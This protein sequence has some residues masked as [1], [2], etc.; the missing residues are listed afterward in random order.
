MKFDLIRALSA[1]EGKAIPYNPAFAGDKPVEIYS[2]GGANPR[3]NAKLSQ[4]N[5][6]RHLDAMGGSQAVDWLADCIR[7]YGDTVATAKWHL[8]KDD[9]TRLVRK[10]HKNTPKDYEEGPKDLYNLLR[11]PN[12]FMDYAELFDLMVADLLLVGNAYWYKWQTT[13]DGKPLALYR[14]APGYVKIVPGPFG[15]KRYEYS[16][17][18]SRNKLDI[19]PDDIVHMRLPNPNN[20]YYG[21][22]IVQGGG[23]AFDLELALTDTQASYMENHADPSVV[24]QSERRVPRDVFK[25]LHLQLRRRASGP[26]NAGELLVLEAG[27]KADTLSHS[28]R[29]NLFD[30]LTKLSRDRVYAKFRASPKLFGITDEAGGADKTS[31]ARREFDTKTM[32]PFLDK[33]QARVTAGLVA[34]WGLEYKID[35]SYVLPPEELVQFAGNISAVPGIKVREVRR[36]LAPLGLDESTGDETIDE[37][38]LNL[39]G[40]NLDANGN[41]I[42]PGG[43]PAA[44]GF[45]DKNL[46]GEPGRP[47]KGASTRA[48]P[49]KGQPT[50]AGATVVRPKASGK[51]LMA[52]LD[53]RLAAVEQKALLNRPSGAA[54]SRLPSEKRPDDTLHDQRQAEVDAAASYIEGELA[55]AARMLERDLMDRADGKAFKANDVVARIRRSPAWRAFS[56][57]VNRV[58]EDGAKRAISAAVVQHSEQGLT[59]DQEL[60]YDAL[61]KDSLYRKGGIQKVMATLRDRMSKAVKPVRDAGGSREQINKIVQD[62]ITEWRSG[63]AAKIAAT[64]AVAA[65]NEGTLAVAEA[66]GVKEVFV[67]DGHDTDA[68]CEEADGSVWT[69]EQARENRLEHP[70]CRRGFVPLTSGA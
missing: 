15:P 44:A 53:G 3:E 10:K 32:R 19:S 55:K 29:E 39:P 59:S 35:Y 40:N 31:D 41:P 6:N 42:G 66:A 2:P 47:P 63:Q 52:E 48:F 60:D 27:L 16:P 14:L 69:I 57:T 54:N 45:A 26:R 18:G 64:E 37:T 22:G 36:I 5:A 28:A 34:A 17:P 9:G 62:T 38:V 24:V 23:R 65:Y 50:P 11:A 33:L 30:T 12:P 58:L 68:P 56:A 46:P 21:L 1:Q 20:T 61:A 4:R 51:A 43:A 13:T 70:N 49:K 8:E 7:L 25:K 67:S